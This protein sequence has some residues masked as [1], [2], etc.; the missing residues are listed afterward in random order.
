MY[1]YFSL[2]LAGMFL[3]AV[4][5]L[6]IPA[7]SM[8]GERAY[9]SRGTA[10]F[11]SA[12]GDFVGSGNA[13][14]LGKYTEVGNAVISGLGEV[15]AWAIYTAA[16]GD[17]LHATFEGQINEFGAISASVTYAGGTGRFASASGSA[18]LSGQIQPDGTLVVFVDGKIDY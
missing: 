13:T 15:S 18:T 16:D 6:A 2:K 7:L 4:S 12:E 3:V 14:H 10:H 1:R 9:Q 5:A 8:A 17:E 11:V